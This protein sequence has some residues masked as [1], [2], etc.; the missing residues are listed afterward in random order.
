MW[1]YCWTV[2]YIPNPIFVYHAVFSLLC[3]KNM[4]FERCLLLQTR[5]I[6]QQVDGEAKYISD[7]EITHVDCRCGRLFY[8]KFN[9]R[10]FYR[11][12]PMVHV[13][14]YCKLSQKITLVTAHFCNS[15]TANFCEVSKFCYGDVTLN[16]VRDGRAFWA[17]LKTFDSSLCSHVCSQI[18]LNGSDRIFVLWWNMLLTMAIC[19]RNDQDYKYYFSDN[20]PKRRDSPADV[21]WLFWQ[22]KPILTQNCIRFYGTNFWPIFIS[23]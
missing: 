17:V 5:I 20:R 14:L 12:F 22:I 21:Y 10:L 3:R 11:K 15:C 13:I 16:N 18:Y 23:L 9:F 4:F 7:G 2:I 8:G 1:K 19:R 6:C